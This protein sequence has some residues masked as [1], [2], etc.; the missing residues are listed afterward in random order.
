VSIAAAR[1]IPTGQIVALKK[2]RL[3]LHGS[4]VV[5]FWHWLY[6][7]ARS[8]V[9]YQRWAVEKIEAGHWVLCTLLQVRF[10]GSKEGL[11]VTSVRELTILQQA[12]HPNI[13]SLLK[14]VTGSRPDRYTAQTA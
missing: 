13:V 5:V 9:T 10:T 4:L 2:V 7:M 1:H 14:V 11:P 6:P 8:P 3:H 12:K